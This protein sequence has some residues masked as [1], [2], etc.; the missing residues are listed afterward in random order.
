MSV[1]GVKSTFCTAGML[2]ML[3][4]NE[5]SVI[6]QNM[7][8]NYDVNIIEYPSENNRTRFWSLEVFNQHTLTKQAL[9]T[10]AGHLRMFRS[11]D[12]VVNFIIENCNN[13]R[14]ITVFYNTEQGQGL[15]KVAGS[16]NQP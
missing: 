16:Q 8:Q 1:K 6:N 3:T 11:F 9:Y 13:A 4:L 14:Q 2:V 15:I 5:L 12:A 10:F 7:A